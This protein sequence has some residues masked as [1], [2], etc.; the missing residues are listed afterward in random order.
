MAK[1][2]REAGE[3]P[4]SISLDRDGG[5]HLEAPLMTLEGKVR[6]AGSDIDIRLFLHSPRP[7]NE[8]RG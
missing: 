3:M 7:E 6:L 5:L 2:N 1:V 4:T 8:A